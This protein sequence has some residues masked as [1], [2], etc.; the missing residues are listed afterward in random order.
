[1]LR[2][3]PR[4]RNIL[5]P[6]LNVDYTEVG[7]QTYHGMTADE[8]IT[9][10]SHEKFV[11]DP[12]IHIQHLIGMSKWQKVSDIEAIGHHQVRAAHQR[13][14]SLDRRTVE[15]KGHGHGMVV[16]WYEKLMVPGN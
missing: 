13:Y 2:T 14:T 12:L 8:F 15:A 3:G 10:A 6:H 9:V 16:H 1:M 5:A 4:L 11:G 7:S